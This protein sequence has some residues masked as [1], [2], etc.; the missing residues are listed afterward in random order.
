MSRKS[1]LD[2]AQSVYVQTRRSTDSSDPCWNY[3][4]LKAALEAAYDLGRAAQAEK[5][6]DV[7]RNYNWIVAIDAAE[8]TAK[9]L[10]AKV[11]KAAGETPTKPTTENGCPGADNRKGLT[12]GKR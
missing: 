6:I 7:M 3:D 1:D 9:R 12:E 11:R 5:D 8:L 4:S 2:L 10:R